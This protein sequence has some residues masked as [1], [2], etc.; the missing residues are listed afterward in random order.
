M[1]AL[2]THYRF[3]VDEYERMAVVGILHE[4][5][6][7]ELIDGEI[8]QMAAIGSRHMFCVNRL[9]GLLTQAITNPASVSVQNPIRLP[10]DSEPEPDVVVLREGITEDAVPSPDDVLLVIEVADSTLAYDRTVKF[11][12]YARAG[13]AEAWLVD[14]EGGRIE[15]HSE[16]GAT[17]YRLIAILERGDTLVSTVLPAVALSVEAILGK[18][19]ESERRD[20]C[21]TKQSA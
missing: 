17:G 4:D 16:P 13:I 1:E 19:R 18:P 2:I 9:T 14:L 20:S 8:V 12:R 6:R 11:P 5:D 15:R 10:N 7:V 21:I 3:T